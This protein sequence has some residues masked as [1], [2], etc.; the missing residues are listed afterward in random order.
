MTGGRVEV[1][2][3]T[4]VLTLDSNRTVVAGSEQ[5]LVDGIRNGGDLRIYTEF[6]HNEHIEVHSNFGERGRQVAEFGV[7]YPV[8]QR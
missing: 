3:R 8:E 5:A 6:L 7:T 4:P 2:Q 1:T